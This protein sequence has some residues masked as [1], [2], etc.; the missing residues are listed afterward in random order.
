MK[1][2]FKSLESS[3]KLQAQTS[4]R[5]QKT[6]AEF[7][8]ASSKR[9]SNKGKIEQQFPTFSTPPENVRFR[10]KNRT[11][12]L[13]ERVRPRKTK[14]YTVEKTGDAEQPDQAFY[15]RFAQFSQFLFLNGQI[16]AT[17]FKDPD[18][19]P[20]ELQTILETNSR[21]NNEQLGEINTYSS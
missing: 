1:H 19:Q 18:A 6:A 9:L 14:E 21:I 17:R 5:T 2:P 4:H 3:S 11:I 13:Q 20:I 16:H 10:S 12:S 8:T 7:N 15:P